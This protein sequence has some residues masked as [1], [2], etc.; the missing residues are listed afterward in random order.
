M[1]K[2]REDL[3]GRLKDQLEKLLE[4]FSEDSIGN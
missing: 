4:L 1:K 2:V 3:G